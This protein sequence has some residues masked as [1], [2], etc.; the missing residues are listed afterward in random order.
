MKILTSIRQYAGQLDGTL[1]LMLEEER[2]LS[3]GGRNALARCIDTVR[4][5]L[6][7][8]NDYETK[9]PRTAKSITKT[10]NILGESGVRPHLGAE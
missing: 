10:E 8:I 5:I 2:E 7:E 9:V 3:S 4:N 6:E 1:T